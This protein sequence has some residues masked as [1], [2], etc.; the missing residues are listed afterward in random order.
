MEK[1]NNKYETIFIVDVTK[2]EE[3]VKALIEKFTSLISQNGEILEVNEWGKRRLA[4]LIND[5]SEG[6]YVL[7]KFTAPATFIAE[8]KRIYKITEGIMRSLVVVA[9]DKASMPAR[10]VNDAPAAEKEVEAEVEEATEAVE[11]TVALDDVV[12]A[13]EETVATET[14]EEE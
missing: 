9:D 11:E 5:M 2:G 10:A 1:A 14:T 13:V 4:Y 12:S 6:Y 8:L 7:V 3:A